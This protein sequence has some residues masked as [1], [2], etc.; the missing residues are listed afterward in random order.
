[1]TTDAWGNKFEHGPPADWRAR[2][3]A[4]EARLAEVEA[5]WKKY[6]ARLAEVEAERG[7]AWAIARQ[8]ELGYTARLAEVEAERQAWESDFRDMN[9]AHTAAE[10]RLAE[11][12]AERDASCCV[13]TG[14]D[15]VASLQS[16]LSRQ[17]ARLAEVEAERE[18]LIEA[19]AVREHDYDELAALRAD[20]LARCAGRL[21]RLKS[22]EA[23]LATIEVIAFGE[24]GNQA[25]KMQAIRAV[26]RGDGDRPAERSGWEDHDPPADH[27]AILDGPPA[28]PCAHRSPPNMPDEVIAWRCTRCGEVISE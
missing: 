22:A 28:E 15:A 24:A 9:A 26:L 13:G 8:V 14:C 5:L 2:A 20:H 19:A 7:R 23:R 21:D 11:V 3:M 4:A 17:H 10:A 16:E 1:M 12:E 27:I 18:G 6:R 25:A